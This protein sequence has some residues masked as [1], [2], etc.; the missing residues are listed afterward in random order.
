MKLSQWLQKYRPR[1]SPADTQCD[2]LRSLVADFNLSQNDCGITNSNEFLDAQARAGAD[3]AG[4]RENWMT[5]VELRIL[6][7]IF[8]VCVVVY[9][10]YRSTGTMTYKSGPQVNTEL[11]AVTYTM[12]NPAICN[13]TEKR[14][15][16]KTVWLWNNVTTL[17]GIQHYE[18]LIDVEFKTK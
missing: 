14:Q 2:A 7:C 9:K 15:S 12:V 13:E 11:N 17:R 18:L 5:D 10:D 3:N 1:V 16:D 6:G 4:V 8:N